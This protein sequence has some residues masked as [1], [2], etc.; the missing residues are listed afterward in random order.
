MVELSLPIVASLQSRIATAHTVMAYW[1]LPDEV[2]THSLIDHL[3]AAGIRV[4][5]PH[6]TGPTTMELHQY[7]GIASMTPGAFGIMEPTG[8]LFTDY[9]AVDTV[10][11][12][13]I[14]F[15]RQ[16]HRLGRGRGYYDRLLPLLP[17]AT[18]I[19]LCFPFQLVEHV[20]TDC[21]DITMDE[22]VCGDVVIRKQGL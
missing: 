22:V 8:S 2:F 9:A 20:P 12:P 16:G 5:L 10:I 4:V 11:V 1:S 7:T 21:H 6:V 17:N 19:G 18:T 15:D 3:T 14:A 13:G